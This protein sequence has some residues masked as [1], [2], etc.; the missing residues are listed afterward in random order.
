[1]VPPFSAGH[2]CE[3]LPFLAF[4]KLRANAEFTRMGDT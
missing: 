1:M 2:A 3:S 4:R